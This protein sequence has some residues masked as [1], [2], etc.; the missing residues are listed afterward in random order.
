M[1]AKRT[2]LLLIGGGHTH[3]EV[4]RRWAQPDVDVTLVSASPNAAYSGMLTGLIAGHY[5]YEQTHIDL[6]ALCRK[7]NVNFASAAVTGVNPDLQHAF[8]DDGV[9]RS[10]DVA[11]INTGSTP[12]VGHVP[13]ACEHAA[14]VKPVPLFLS[15]WQ[16]FL[17]ERNAANDPARVVVV[18]GGPGGVEL[19]FAMQHLFAA[20]PESR[21]SS[22]TFTLIADAVLPKQS[23]SVQRRTLRL[24]AA[25][26]IRVELSRAVEMSAN[27]VHTNSGNRI[28]AD[29]TVFATPASAPQWFAESGL[30]LDPQGFVA[31]NGHL[32]SLSHPHIYA[33]GDAAA[34][35]ADPAPKSGVY[36]VR[37]GPILHQNLVD[38]LCNRKPSATFKPQRRALYIISCGDK[39]GI[40]CYGK[41][42]LFGR[43]MWRIK[44]AI[45]RRF[46]NRY[47]T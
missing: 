34:L 21:S 32:Q 35:L 1:T 33:A 8:C 43:L 23:R 14:R 7:M 18:G 44:D 15:R 22:A 46:M 36:A 13:G 27:T 42:A 37:E 39:K 24:L 25:K 12:S 4:V 26:N 41:I 38:H 17:K 20:H 28:P 5:R 40:L 29:F 30:A 10:F 31:V 11:S 16:D 3:V 47:A 19:V 45:D 2:R 6:P 9:T